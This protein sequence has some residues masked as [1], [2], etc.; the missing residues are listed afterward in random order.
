M[1]DLDLGYLR[2]WAKELAVPELLEELLR[3]Q[4]EHPFAVG[5]LPLAQT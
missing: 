3:K 1:I 5:F 4:L 2:L